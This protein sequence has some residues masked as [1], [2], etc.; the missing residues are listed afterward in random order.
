[1]ILMCACTLLFELNWKCALIQ[2]YLYN[3]N[4]IR[5]ILHVCTIMHFLVFVIEQELCKKL[6][7]SILHLME[8]GPMTLTKGWQKCSQEKEFA[9]VQCVTPACQKLKGNVWIK[10]AVSAWKV[11]KRQQVVLT[12]W[13]QHSTAQQT[14]VDDVKNKTSI[15]NRI[16]I[17]FHH[18]VS[19]IWTFQ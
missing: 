4:K 11:Q 8:Y 5:L 3:F 2:F 7:K 15:L 13:G 12:S 16:T 6:W 19:L 10:T 1:M 17:V 14:S 18:C 9:S